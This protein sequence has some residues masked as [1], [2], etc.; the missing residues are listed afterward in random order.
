MFFYLIK[1]PYFSFQVIQYSDISRAELMCQFNGWSQFSIPL[2]TLEVGLQHK[3]LDTV[4]FFLKSR[5]KGK[6]LHILT[7]SSNFVEMI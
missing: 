5:E 3:Q 7:E 1:G 6:C 2:H 4:A